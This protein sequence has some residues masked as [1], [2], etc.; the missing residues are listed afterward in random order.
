MELKDY[1]QRV[2]ADLNEYLTLLENTQLLDVAFK[3]YWAEKTSL[4]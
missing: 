4:I 3:Q 2:I 1:Q